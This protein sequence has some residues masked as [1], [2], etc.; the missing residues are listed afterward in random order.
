MKRILDPAFRYVPSFET[1]V[2]KT[3][4]RARREQQEA[5]ERPAPDPRVLKLAAPKPAGQSA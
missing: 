2:R 4:E 3:F 1:D 5:R